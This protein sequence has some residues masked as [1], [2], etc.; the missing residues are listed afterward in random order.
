ML[1]KLNHALGI[2]AGNPVG[3]LITPRCWQVDLVG[4]P[5]AIG[6]PANIVAAAGVRG[7]LDIHAILTVSAAGIAAGGVVT[8]QTEEINIITSI[9]FG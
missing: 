5:F 6:N 3:H 1:F 8:Q 7:G 4:Q 2:K 9:I